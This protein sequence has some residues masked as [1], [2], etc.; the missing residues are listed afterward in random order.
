MEAI[1]VPVLANDAAL[2][3][4]HGWDTIKVVISARHALAE[5]LEAL[6]ANLGP[7]ASVLTDVTVLHAISTLTPADVI[8]L[9][10]ERPDLVADLARKARA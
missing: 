8:R 6:E 5:A 10:Q 7:D 1:K 3:G 4:L 2:P 9:A